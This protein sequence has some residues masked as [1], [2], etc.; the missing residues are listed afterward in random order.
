MSAADGP[1]PRVLRV[2]A[3]ERDGALAGDVQAAP[4]P[5]GAVVLVHGFASGRRGAKA[6]HL[7]RALPEL[8]WTVVA[9]DLQGHGDSGGSFAG[10]TIERSI[11]DVLRV[12]ALP[13]VSD[14]PRRVLC[15]SSFGGLVAAWTAVEHPALFERLVLIAPAFGFLDR[16]VGGL[17]AGALRAWEDGRPHRA[18]TPAGPRD[19][20]ADIVRER[21]RRPWRRVA[22]DLRTPTL[23]VHGRQDTSVPWEASAR[24]VAA[25]G[26]DVVRAAYLD[27]ADHRMSGHLDALV[28][29]VA[30]FLGTPPGGAA[31]PLI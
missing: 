29:L 28:E 8:G 24:F 21:P 11:R 9:P 15:G 17:S 26:R 5:V 10:L 12:A 23:L 31:E 27:A 20:D 13:E 22:A 14:A 30:A 6:R 16:Y 25:T 3:D 7:S 2:P 19:L 1:Q 18:Q 4:E